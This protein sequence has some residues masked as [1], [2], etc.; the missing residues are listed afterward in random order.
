M[1]ISNSNT[2][3][4]APLIGT[5]H[6]KQLRKQGQRDVASNARSQAGP[7]RPMH[8][9][10]CARRTGARQRRKNDLPIESAIIGN[11]SHVP[12]LHRWPLLLDPLREILDRVTIPEDGIDPLILE[13]VGQLSEHRE[14]ITEAG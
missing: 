13:P 14:N 4:V 1:L 6:V 5:C 9:K 10:R 2:V 7:S 3:K 11:I 12:Q 8:A